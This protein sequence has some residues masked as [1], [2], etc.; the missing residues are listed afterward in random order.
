MTA[1]PF[2]PKKRIRICGTF[3]SI[4]PAIARKDV[5]TL[6]RLDILPDAEVM[7]GQMRNSNRR[8]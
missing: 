7:A 4:W 8:E 2:C 6:L 5:Q 1:R 3:I